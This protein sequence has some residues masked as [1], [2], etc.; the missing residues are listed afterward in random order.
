MENLLGLVAAHEYYE[1][2]INEVQCDTLRAYMART[3]NPVSVKEFDAMQCEALNALEHRRDAV[4]R[5]IDCL[6]DNL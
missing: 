2:K 6:V 1:K 4:A 5:A 3:G